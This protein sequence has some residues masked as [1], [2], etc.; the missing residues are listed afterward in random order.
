LYNNFRNKKIKI[1]IEQKTK[2]TIKQK[3]AWLK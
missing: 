2:G 3:E 1:K